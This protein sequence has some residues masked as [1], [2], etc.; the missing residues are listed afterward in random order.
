MRARMRRQWFRGSK[1]SLNHPN[2]RVRAFAVEAKK[3]DEQ[4]RAELRAMME[5]DEMVAYHWATVEA[6]G[7]AEQ[8]AA[9]LA[10]LAD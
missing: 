2:H 9:M 3:R 8:V 10:E 5:A 1:R 6:A 7:H 4:V